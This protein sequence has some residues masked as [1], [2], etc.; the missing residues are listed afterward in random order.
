MSIFK[1]IMSLTLV[2]LLV[3][4]CLPTAAFADEVEVEAG[5]TEEAIVE[6]EVMIQGESFA[7]ESAEEFPA[8][9]PEEEPVQEEEEII[10]SDDVSETVPED[11]EQDPAE[12]ITP[13]EDP[14]VETDPVEAATPEESEEEE[15]LE[16]EPS[17]EES[18]AESESEEIEEDTEQEEIEDEPEE[19]V[20]V[21]CTFTVELQDVRDNITIRRNGQVVAKVYGNPAPGDGHYF[22]VG[23]ISLEELAYDAD[24]I[25]RLSFDAMTGDIFSVETVQPVYAKIDYYSLYNYDVSEQ[26]GIAVLSITMEGDAS[27]QVN[28]DYSAAAGFF[29]VGS[30][31][32]D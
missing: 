19:P 27:I 32:V 23:P 1:K 30:R 14:E 18:D 28:G 20:P 12:E 17:V 26:N 22:I 25:T 5:V 8:E 11:I 10:V 4:S 24:G 29:P 3:F 21:P 13:E 6:N 16:K 7:E 31:K 15:I 9:P 2:F